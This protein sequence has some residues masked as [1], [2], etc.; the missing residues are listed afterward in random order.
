MTVGRY[1]PVICMFLAM[2]PVFGSQKKTYKIK[3]VGKSPNFIALNRDESRLYATSFGT[4]E[5]IGVNLSKKVVEQRVKVG[6]SPLGFDLIDQGRMALVACKDDGVVAIVDLENFHVVGDIN[7]GGTP[8]SVT[9]SPRGYRAY[10]TDYGRTREGRLHIVDVR[11][12][13]VLAT[14]EMGAAPFTIRNRSKSWG[15][16]MWVRPLMALPCRRTASG[17]TLPTVSQTICRS[18][19]QPICVSWSRFR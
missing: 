7:V 14:M 8:N 19:I 11:D 1:F 15:R 16:L 2:L 18:S 13:K 5:F 6:N 12:R 17:Y 4:N 9:V 10:V 3:K